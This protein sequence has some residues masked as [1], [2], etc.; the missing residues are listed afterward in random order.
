MSSRCLACDLVQQAAEEMY[1]KSAT[2]QAT[3]EYAALHDA[4]QR[5]FLKAYFE[6]K[7]GKTKESVE[8]AKLILDRL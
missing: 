5:K 4:E 8:S 1:L 6:K 3:A 2:D 7:L